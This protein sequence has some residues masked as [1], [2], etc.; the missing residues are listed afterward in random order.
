MGGAKGGLP[1]K[2]GGVSQAEPQGAA[3]TAAGPGRSTP[4]LWR[5]G[6][7]GCGCFPGGGLLVAC[8]LADVHPES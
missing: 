6:C 2:W 1:E 5:G 8:Q 7:E 4:G 3:V